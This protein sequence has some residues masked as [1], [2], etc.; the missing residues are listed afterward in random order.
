MTYPEF[1]KAED[2]LFNERF[3]NLN[4]STE[5]G[6]HDAK[7][8]VIDFMHAS[9]KR[10]I[11]HLRGEIEKL[12]INHSGYVRDGDGDLLPLLDEIL[13]LLQTNDSSV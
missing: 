6:G 11:E 7:P 13:A 5:E 1:Q 12:T 10:F 2:A 4:D 3:F 8:Y 9:R